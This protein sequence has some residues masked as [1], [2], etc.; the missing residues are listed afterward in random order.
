MLVRFSI[1]SPSPSAVPAGA[2]GPN[3]FCG[4]RFLVRPFPSGT[5]YLQNGSRGAQYCARQAQWPRGRAD[6]FGADFLGAD[7]LG[8]DFLGADFL[9]AGFLGA[10]F[11]GA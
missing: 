9:G 1:V 10:D 11:F 6:F 3:R 4:S 8:A 7:F 2:F 5:G